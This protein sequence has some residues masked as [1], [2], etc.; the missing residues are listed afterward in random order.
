[1]MSEFI[2]GHFDPPKHPK[3]YIFMFSMFL[4]SHIDG[5]G[6]ADAISNSLQRNNHFAERVI[7]TLIIRSAFTS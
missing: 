6:R 7:G 5:P 1:M 4:T 3:T 2:A